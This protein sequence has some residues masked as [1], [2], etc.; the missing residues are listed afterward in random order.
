MLRYYR[1]IQNPPTSPRTSSRILGSPVGRCDGLLSCARL[2][3]Q[4]GC[5]W[6]AVWR[7]PPHQPM[8]CWTSRL[9]DPQ[10]VAAYLSRAS[11]A[12]H[13][14]WVWLGVE[15]HVAVTAP[16]LGAPTTCAASANSMPQLTVI[17][18]PLVG[19]SDGV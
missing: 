8:A 15:A 18:S 19:C 3:G 13:R 4:P 11:Y 17:G 12:P 2:S 7:S 10:F 16:R 6:A 5:P 1:R 14:A 9:V